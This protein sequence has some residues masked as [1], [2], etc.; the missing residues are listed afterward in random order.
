MKLLI[1]QLF[2]QR[3]AHFGFFRPADHA[4]Y[5]VAGAFA[6]LRYAAFADSL[7]P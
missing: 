1:C 5:R 2:F 4:G 7:I 6:A 3:P